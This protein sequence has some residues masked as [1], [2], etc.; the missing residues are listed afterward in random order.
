MHTDIDRQLLQDVLIRLQQWCADWQLTINIDKCHV[1]NVGRN[2]NNNNYFINMCELSA[3]AIVR[4]LG[5]EVDSTVNF[6]AHI[7]SIIGKAYCRIVV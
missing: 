1:L 5:I 2:S 4:D 7:N 6:D 3:T